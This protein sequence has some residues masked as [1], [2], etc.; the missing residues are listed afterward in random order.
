MPRDRLIQ[1]RRGT[2]VQ[3]VTANP[4]L[5]S[6]EMGFE[7]D[8]HKLK[9][10]DGTT[11]WLALPYTVSGAAGDADTLDGYDATYFAVAGHTH[12]QSEVTSLVSD[13]GSKVPI[14][15]TVNGY[16][17]TGNITLAY[18]DVGAAA[19]SHTHVM[20]DITDTEQWEDLR[21]PAVGINPPGAPSD[22]TRD[23]SDG[24]LV[25]SGTIDNVI[26]VQ[27]QLPHGWTEGSSIIPHLHWSPT[28][29]AAGN[30][31]WRLQWKIANRGDAFP[32][33]WST[34]TITTATSET[35]EMHEM[36]NF[37]SI[38]MTGKTISCMILFLLTR[39]AGSD[40]LDTYAASVKLAEFD[41]HYLHTRFGATP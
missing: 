21:F 22:A 1:V 23:A 35:A 34:E 2:L 6:G 38:S 8:T 26:A 29:S 18:T 9:V 14:T 41:I 3:W 10:G 39:L 36:D 40:T 20:A 32:G 30:V 37:S 15:R 11:A 28:T 13:L 16:Q 24:R 4:T 12:P 5:A 17:L 25:F 31:R 33:S 19:S 7:T 27:A